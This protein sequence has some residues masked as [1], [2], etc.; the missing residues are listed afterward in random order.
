[1]SRG[2]LPGLSDVDEQRIARHVDDLSKIRHRDG[3]NV[4]LRS[5]HFLSDT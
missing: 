3:P 2:V 1:M 4:L 5:E